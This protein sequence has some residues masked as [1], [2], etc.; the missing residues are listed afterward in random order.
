MRRGERKVVWFPKHAVIIIRQVIQKC[1]HVSMV[2]P[3][4]WAEHAVEPRLLLLSSL[5]FHSVFNTTNCTLCHCFRWTPSLLLL[6]LLLSLLF[7]L[8]SLPFHPSIIIHHHAS[9]SICV[10]SFRILGTEGNAWMEMMQRKKG[11]ETE[12]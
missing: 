1:G 11:W 7:H 2:A 8:L 9:S 6:L 5:L 3:P 4:E 10:D 12:T